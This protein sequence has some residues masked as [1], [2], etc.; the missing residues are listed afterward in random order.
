MESYPLVVLSSFFLSPALAQ[1][2]LS[3]LSPLPLSP[4][5][6][7]HFLLLQWELCVLQKRKLRNRRQSTQQ[8]KGDK[9]MQGQPW[10]GV[11][12]EQAM[13]RPGESRIP[14]LVKNMIRQL[15]DQ[16]NGRKIPLFEYI[17][18]LIIPCSWSG[19][20]ACTEGL[21]EVKAKP[22]PLQNLKFS[23]NKGIF[24]HL[25]CLFMLGLFVASLFDC[26]FFSSV[27]M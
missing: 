13:Q 25:F 4:S 19:F 15:S 26:F 22:L 2:I 18:A 11:P 21:F 16:K 7:P 23:I 3:P 24:I 10:F 12:L 5:P 20:S 17:K 1:S 27:T 9:R 8:R 6:S 14:S